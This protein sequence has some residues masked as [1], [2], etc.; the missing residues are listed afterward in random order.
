MKLKKTLLHSLLLLVVSLQPVFA[1]ADDQESMELNAKIEIEKVSRNIINALRYGRFGLADAEWKKIQSDVY[2]SFAEYDYLNGSLLYSRMEWQEA[3]ESLNRTLKKE[4]NHEAASFLLGMIYAQEDSWSEAKET[5]IETNQISPYN[6][7]Y[8]YNLG[9]AYF[10]LKDYPNAIISLNKSL[11]Y[12]A[13][14]N[15]AKLILAKTYLELGQVD[16][17][18]IELSSIL[19]QDPKHMQ[20][21]H[22]MGRVI[23]LMDK[24]PK[25]SLTYLKNPRALGWREKKVYAR[26]YFE[27]RKWREAE[28]LLRPIAY[29]PFAD[30]YDQSFYLN[31]LLNLGFDERANDFFHFI[32]KQSQNE[33]KI[34]EAYRMLLSSREGKDL[35]YHYFKLRY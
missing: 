4:P 13:N 29:S 12:K 33:S 28:N 24:D 16:K 27:M 8:H 25:K 5:W 2:K 20:A 11:E 21:S 18:K 10:I 3:K 9:L 35:L 6:P 32:Q 34:A 19:E 22:L 7:F 14:Y 30:E 31:L 15:E 23:Y 1:D 17:A 26:C